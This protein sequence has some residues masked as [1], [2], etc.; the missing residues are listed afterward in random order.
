MNGGSLGDTSDCYSILANNAVL[1][2]TQIQVTNR[3]QPYVGGLQDLTSPVELRSCKVIDATSGLL[4]G[5]QARKVALSSRE[6]ECW[7]PTRR[8]T[9]SA[10]YEY[11]PAGGTNQD[12]VNVGVNSAIAFTATTL[13][14]DNTDPNSFCVDD[15]IGWQFL[16]IGKSVNTFKLPGAKVTAINSN[17]ISCNLLYPRSYYDETYSPASAQIYLRMWAPGVALTGDTNS[18]TTLSN[19]SP[20]TILQNGD[21]ITAAAGLPAKTRVRSG[22]G[23]ATITLSRAATDT[24]AGKTLYWDRLNTP[25]LTPAF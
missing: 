16:A 6:S 13:T 21:W 9:G 11:I 5:S 7:S 24:A 20:T 18:N 2:G 3:F 22:S 8:V 10:I 19:V 23:T 15:L 14:F 25:T 17:T 1:T 4:Y 12:Y